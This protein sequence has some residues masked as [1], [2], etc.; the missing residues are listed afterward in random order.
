MNA[1]AADVR[2]G[3]F[4]TLGVRKGPFSASPTRVAA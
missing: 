1:L 2:K 4:I 3:P